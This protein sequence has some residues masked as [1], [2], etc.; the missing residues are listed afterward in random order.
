MS[1]YDY[2]VLGGGI[3]GLAIAEIFARSGFSVCIVERNDQLCS[4][5]SG[6]HHE[7][8]HFGSLYSI[9]PSN[10]FLRTVV[11]GIDDLLL[12]YR[13]FDGMNLRVSGKGD[14]ITVNK[15]N[16]WIREDNLK[17]V[18]SSSCGVHDLSI[19]ISSIVIASP[20]SARKASR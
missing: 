18:T 13:D 11:G 6:M 2:T 10:Q 20:W 7:W 19:S 8:F 3:A 14:L 16:N 12:Y 15:D 17:Y 1:K 9:F 5:T 4:E